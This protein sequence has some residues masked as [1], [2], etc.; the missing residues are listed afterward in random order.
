MKKYL[1]TIL[2]V[3]FCSN[4]LLDTQVEALTQ[5]DCIT[6]SKKDFNYNAA[7][8]GMDGARLMQQTTLKRCQAEQAAETY[9]NID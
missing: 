1:F 4:A 3:S 7:F 5:N 8:Y 9:L 2:F 6:L